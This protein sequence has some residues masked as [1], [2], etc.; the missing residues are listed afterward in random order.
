VKQLYACKMYK[1]STRK[2]KIQA[3][4][5]NP[6]NQPLVTQLRSYLDDEYRKE[7][8]LEPDIEMKKGKGSPVKDE[9]ID[10]SSKD[11]KKLIDDKKVIDDN[12]KFSNPN[13]GKE[14]ID[15]E[16]AD[17]DNNSSED[18]NNV[19]SSKKCAIRSS[20]DLDSLKGTMNAVSDT[21]GV[22]RVKIDEDKKELWVY[23][24]DDINLNDIMT[25]LIELLESSSYNYLIFNRLARSGNA[26]VFEIS[27]TKVDTLESPK[28]VEGD[29]NE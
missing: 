26:V 13:G 17:K 23:Y 11:G 24:N 25:P 10:E 5:S 1:S 15:V 6:V 28:S 7:E 21:C 4:L 2:S 3:A 8:I 19:N 14:D 20:I 12:T 18:D 22:Q 9:H 29:K 16:D 27:S